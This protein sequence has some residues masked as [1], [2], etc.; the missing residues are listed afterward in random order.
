MIVSYTSIGYQPVTE[1]KPAQWGGDLYPTLIRKNPIRPIR[2]FLKGGR[3]DINNEHG[4][5]FLA[6]QQLLSALQWANSNGV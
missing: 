3:N 1:N 4:D 2:I 5:W 6:S